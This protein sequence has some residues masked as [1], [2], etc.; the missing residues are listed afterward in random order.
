MVG[1]ARRGVVQG[2]IGFSQRRPPEAAGQ[3]SQ[4][5]GAAS[6]HSNPSLT[7]TCPCRFDRAHSRDRA[8]RRWA[9]LMTLA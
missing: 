2:R 6:N 8:R 9:S 3:V 1:L 7:G 4:Q 5:D